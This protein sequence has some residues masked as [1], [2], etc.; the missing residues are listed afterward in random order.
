VARLLGIKHGP[1][2]EAQREKFQNGLLDFRD[3]R[4]SIFD[5]KAASLKEN[6]GA[7]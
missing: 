3:V 6:N 1:L 7:R 4:N 2:T 5:K